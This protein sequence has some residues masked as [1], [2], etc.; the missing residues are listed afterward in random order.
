M[1]KPVPVVGSGH[2]GGCYGFSLFAKHGFGGKILLLLCL[3]LHIMGLIGAVDY[4][5]SSLE[6]VP[7][8]FPELFCHRAVFFPLLV[9]FLKFAECLHNVFLPGKSLCLFAELLLHFKVPAEVFVTELPV[10]FH[11]VVELFHIQ[12]IGFV[13]VCD[14]AC[15]HRTYF[16]PAV[17]DFPECRESCVHVFLLFDEGFEVFNYLFLEFEIVLALL[18]HL[19]VVNGTLPLVLGINFLETLFNCKERIFCTFHKLFHLQEGSFLFLLELS[20]EGRF[21]GF[22]PFVQFHSFLSGCYLLQ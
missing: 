5:C 19:L 4:S 9:E 3:E 22:H 11:Q 21:Y 7:D 6:P 15:R 20:V 2:I 14:I 18:L 13:Y 16:T 8:V 17:L 12:G 1:G 10:D